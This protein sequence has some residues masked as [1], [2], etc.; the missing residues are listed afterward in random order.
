MKVKIFA[1]VTFILTVGFVILNTFIV[2]GAIREFEESVKSLDI[3][4]EDAATRANDIYENFKK[5]EVYVSL[6]VNHED[7]TNTKES[8][9]ELI[10]YLE[11][12]DT[13]SAHVTKNRLVDSLE[14]LGRLSGFNISAII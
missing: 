7:L 10:G 2:Q 3:S 13:E 8:F 9:A 12:G 14:H 6:T 11:V 5:K 1:V 4:S